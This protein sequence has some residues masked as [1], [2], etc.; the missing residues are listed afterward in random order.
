MRRNLQQILH[1]R[2]QI[3]GK[4]SEAQ[5]VK[6]R[7][8]NRTLSKR[9]Y[10]L[11]FLDQHRSEAARSAKRPVRAGSFWKAVFIYQDET[12]PFTEPAWNKTFMLLKHSKQDFSR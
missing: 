10:G 8:E 4:S 11:R 12:A 1:H 7:A 3:R 2:L 6:R 9:R 5:V